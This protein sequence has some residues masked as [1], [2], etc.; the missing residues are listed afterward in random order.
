MG[1]SKKATNALR[2]MPKAA[3][4]LSLYRHLG[5]EFPVAFNEYCIRSYATP[6]IEINK[7]RS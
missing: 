3:V 2:P 5:M 7:I 4:R 6:I 1:H